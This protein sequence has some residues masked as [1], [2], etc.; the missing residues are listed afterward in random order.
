MEINAKYKDS[1]FSFLFS[2]PDTLRELYCAIEGITLPPDTPIDINTLSDIIYMDQINDISFTIDNRLVVL[3]EH[4]S[5]VNRNMP[6]RLL[7]Y[8]AR[9]YETIIDRKKLYQSAIEKIPEPEF[10]VLYNGRVPYPEH[11]ILKLSEAFK[12]TA[13][14]RSAAPGSYAL[15]LVVPVYNINKGHNALLIRKSETL[16]GYSTFVDRIRENEK[17]MP[18][19]EAMKA[20]IKYCIENN[21]LK[22]FLETHSS[23][24]FNMLLTEWNTEEAITVN[25]EEAWEGGREEGREEKAME[26]ARNALAEGASLEFVK[27][28]TGLDMEAI[29]NIQI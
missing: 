13:N 14:L 24:V 11:T 23:E 7:L 15:E 10:I 27:K 25:R 4:Q 19:E 9:V 12:D 21:I 17:T 29:R 5:T 22:H 2:N 26:I 3:I 18:R 6:L 20:A 28:I 16:G 8:I 1:V